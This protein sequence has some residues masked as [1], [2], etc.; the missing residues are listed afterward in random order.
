MP[1]TPHT[2]C[3]CVVKKVCVCRGK[4]L[5]LKDLLNGGAEQ[6]YSLFLLGLFESLV[7]LTYADV[8]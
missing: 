1:G 7:L 2:Q 3:V 8:C 5:L 6:C 4:A